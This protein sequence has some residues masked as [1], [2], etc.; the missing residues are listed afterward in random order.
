MS[1]DLKAV[2]VSIQ[3]DGKLVLQEVNHEFRAG[4][5]TL[6]LGRSGSGKTMLLEALSGL[7]EIVQGNVFIGARPL[8]KGS[9]TNRKLQRQAMLLLGTGF[10]HP[11]QQ[12]FAQTVEAEFNYNLRPYRLTT[13]QKKQRISEASF[14]PQ[15]GSDDWLKQDPFKL[16]GGQKRRLTLALL[17]ATAP[18][19]LL[20][21]EPT[22]GVDSVGVAQLCQQLELRKASGKGTIVV[23]H[24]LEGLIE[25]ADHLVFIQAGQ[26]IWSGSP[27]ALLKQP[28][29]LEASGLALPASMETQRMLQE[30][31]FNV[32]NA[33][34]NAIHTAE[35][36]AKQLVNS[37]SNL[38]G[39]KAIKPD[40]EERSP[41]INYNLADETSENPLRQVIKRSTPMKGFDPRAI[42][43][44]YILISSGLLWQTNWVGWGIAAIITLGII[45]FTKVPYKLWSRPAIGLAIFT[46]VAAIF[47][48][49][50]IGDMVG[51]VAQS[52]EVTGLLWQ[53]TPQVHFAFRPAVATFY[54]F[55]RLVMIMLIGFVLL[56]NINH[57][58]LKRALEQGLKG[59]RYLRLPIEQFA[60][61]AALMIRFL[62]LLTYEWEK[63]AR[64]AAARGKY[65]VRPGR[66]PIRG[67]RMTVI[68]YLMSLI[69]LGE[70]LSLILII[71]GIGLAGRK[72]TRVFRLVF[73]KADYK[74]VLVAITILVFL[75]LIAKLT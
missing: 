55:S 74:L 12:L 28:E 35:S 43:L 3:V 57:L 62:P 32:P 42:W 71:R 10:Q 2:D 41:R 67:L 4:S 61:T 17:E 59:L 30:A 37:N 40:S 69:R 22:S 47:S 63:F 6:I 8:W 20:L 51:S 7:R 26:L 27:S 58:H 68:P 56:S 21:D 34:P 75:I 25:T 36:I 24:D 66:V 64:I 18:E 31:G 60:L 49:V 38:N 16:S 44:T 73:Q 52:N 45:Q 39:E 72:E 65:A 50:I 14:L 53:I 54:H 19:W 33:W 46:G 29:L 1:S 5:V 15:Q 13:V 23:T 9:Q 48:G 11:E 70:L